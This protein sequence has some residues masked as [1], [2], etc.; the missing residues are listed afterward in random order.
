M[1]APR[2]KGQSIS[3]AKTA[4]AQITAGDATTTYKLTING[5]VV[6]SYIGSA[7]VAT[8]A[9]GLSSAWNA[10]TEPEAEEITA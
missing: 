3:T 2:W 7:T 1:A 9:T 8:I 6:A 5:K 4:T 10:S